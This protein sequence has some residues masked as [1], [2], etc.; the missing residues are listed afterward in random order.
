YRRDKIGY[1][2]QFMNLIPE[3]NAKENIDLPLILI[4]RPKSYR[5]QRIKELLDL[6]GLGDRAEHH[7]DELS[8]GEQQRIALAVALANNPE[9]ILCDEPTG[10]LDSES[11]DNVL[12]LLKETIKKYPDKVMIIVTHDPELKKI[13]DRLYFIRDGQISHEMTKEEL[14]KFKKRDRENE[15]DYASEMGSGISSIT[16]ENIIQKLRELEYSIKTKIDELEKELR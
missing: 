14:N 3:L 12:S 13:A 6:I 7:P 16:R 9:I 5:E 10:E 4:G 8:G 11:K 15:L 1:V 2:F